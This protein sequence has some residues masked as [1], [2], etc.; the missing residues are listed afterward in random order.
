[1]RVLQKHRVSY[2]GLVWNHPFRYRWRERF[3]NDPII[4]EHATLHALRP[5]L[6]VG[7][8]V[9]ALFAFLAFVVYRPN[10][11]L[12]R[13]VV[14]FAIGSYA[15][16]LTF[17]LVG[18]ELRKS[19]RHFDL[20]LAHLTGVLHVTLQEFAQTPWPVLSARAYAILSMAAEDIIQSEEKFRYPW[21]PERERLRHEFE[22]RY[23]D[24]RKWRLIEDKGYGRYFL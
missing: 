12:L 23:E 9:Y 16:L 8:I 20:D 5:A 1:M 13:I 3:G 15:S 21:H 18:T 24:F 6:L 7:L 4:S 10:V 19:S 2:K 17:L 14:P 22:E 11:A